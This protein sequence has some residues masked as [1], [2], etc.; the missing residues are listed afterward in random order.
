MGTGGVLIVNLAKGRLGEDSTNVLGGW[1]VSTIS[2]AALSRAESPPD[3][4]RPFFLYVDEFQT[5]TTLAFV[6]MMAELR[7]YC[8]GL[9]LAHLHLYQV[10]PDIRHAVLGNVGS[11]ISFRIGAEDAPTIAREFQPIMSVEDVLSLKIA[12]ST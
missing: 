7:K 12:R 3:V 4:R 2:L 10:G 1:I 11:L 5:F 9:V 6:N 8:M